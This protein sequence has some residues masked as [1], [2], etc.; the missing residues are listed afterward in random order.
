MLQINYTNLSVTSV[1]LFISAYS[2][3]S[4]IVRSESDSLRINIT[5]L[6]EHD[7]ITNE[8]ILITEVAYFLAR[9]VSLPVFIVLYLINLNIIFIITIYLMLIILL[10]SGILLKKWYRKYHNSY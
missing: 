8:N 7:E 1:L 6:L 10:V 2:I 4:G 9:I 5:K 3:L